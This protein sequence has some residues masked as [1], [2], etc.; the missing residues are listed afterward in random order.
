MG[1]FS[2][3]R[4]G[5][6]ERVARGDRYMD[7]D[8]P[9]L[10]RAE[11]EAAVACYD[12]KR[13]DPGV[14]EATKRKLIEARDKVARMHL[15]E[16]RL[17]L[18]RN[19]LDDAEE[20]LRFAL[21]TMPT[22]E[23]RQEVEAALR[24]L[25]ERRDALARDSARP[26]SGEPISEE[27]LAEEVDE[28]D[29]AERFER[30]LLALSE[31]RAQAFRSL[32]TAF[33]SG[34][35][36]LQE[37]DAEGAVTALRE[38]LEERPDSPLVHLELGRALLFLERGEE[39][40]GHL[41]AYREVAPDDPDAVYA[42][43]EALRMA[44]RSDEAQAVLTAE[45]ER[46]PHSARAWM[47]LAQFHNSRLQWEEAVV[48][49][50]NALAQLAPDPGARRSGGGWSRAASAA[51]T[52]QQSAQSGD[53][54]ERTPPR[55][56]LLRTLGEAL[57]GAGR[58]AEAIQPLEQALKEYWRYDPETGRLDFDGDSAFLL[59]GVYL[60]RQ[61]RLDRAIEL[62]S[63]LATVSDDAQRPAFLARLG[64]AYGLKGQKKEAERA[65]QQ[66]LALLPEDRVEDRER[67]AELLREHT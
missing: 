53:A 49:A 46:R 14:L 5:F 30:Y 55:I 3:F 34:Y 63:A 60:E 42:L 9:G 32:G 7:Q 29:E 58:L 48:A 56:A 66:A 61:E 12:E 45:T 40:V 44:D 28:E 23:G 4:K 15:E 43:A 37:G 24:E 38:A 25:G 64:R 31:G 8:Q 21:E 36:R 35:V 59:A 50:Q 47:V 65:L 51:A 27:E 52:V 6:A 62:L 13:D 67:V 17:F 20:P 18:S 11:Y 16:G 41:E 10:A 19:M 22:D 33:A 39:A 2:L 57:V 26:F 1:L 54:E